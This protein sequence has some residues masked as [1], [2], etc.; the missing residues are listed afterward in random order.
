M[1]NNSELKILVQS[2]FI[3]AQ[4]MFSLPF[5]YDFGMELVTLSVSDIY[6]NTHDMNAFII[7]NKNSTTA[8]TIRGR[9]YLYIAVSWTNDKM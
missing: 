4:L 2:I 1:H 8:S 9:V 6:N 3:P 5:R 7:I